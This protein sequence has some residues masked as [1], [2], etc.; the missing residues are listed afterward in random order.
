MRQLGY[1]ILSV[2]LTVTGCGV[3]AEQQ[4]AETVSQRH[5]ESWQRGDWNEVL[6]QYDE[7]FY[8]TTTAEAWRTTLL[9]LNRR[10]GG[11]R[12][13][14]LLNS[15]H[16]TYAGFKG[17]ENRLTLTYR[18]R[19]ERGEVMETLSFLDRSGE[20]SPMIVTHTFAPTPE[21]SRQFAGN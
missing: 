17:M 15:S 5:F 11:Y 13:R 6:N 10:L 2:L 8:A 20:G 12:H 1:V 3:S 18:V 9:D 4:A 21:V 16:Q 14:Q 7:T 19:Y